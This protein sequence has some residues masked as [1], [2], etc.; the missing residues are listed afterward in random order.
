[1]KGMKLLTHF[2]TSTVVPLKFGNGYVISSHTLF[3]M[4]LL[5]HAG[6]KVFPCQQKELCAICHFAYVAEIL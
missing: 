4:R 6:I 1:M 3:G 5:I 2:Q